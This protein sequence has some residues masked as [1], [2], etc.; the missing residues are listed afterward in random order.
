MSVAPGQGSDRLRRQRQGPEAHDVEQRRG[1][2]EWPGRLPERSDCLESAGKVERLGDVRR[3]DEEVEPE[4]EGDQRRDGQADGEQ[5]EQHVE[6]RP[7][8]GTR[9]GSLDRCGSCMVGHRRP[10][11]K[12]GLGG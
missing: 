4:A 1:G 10:P 3:R 12:L 2:I 6:R 8:A 7:A 5:P 11:S 9:D